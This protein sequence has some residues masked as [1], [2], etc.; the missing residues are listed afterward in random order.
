LIDS[1]AIAVWHQ[2]DTV[3]DTA[4]VSI[5]NENWLVG[6]IQYYGIGCFLP[7]TMNGEK[8]LAERVNTVGKKLIEVIIIVLSQPAGKGLKL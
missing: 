1:V 7:D 3:D 6:S 4:G 8:L 2:A 5:N